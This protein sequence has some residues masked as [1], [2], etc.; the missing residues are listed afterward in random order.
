M[1]LDTLNDKLDKINERLRKIE[2]KQQFQ[3][4]ENQFGFG[5]LLLVNLLLLAGIGAIAKI[6]APDFANRLQYI[7]LLFAAG[8]ILLVCYNQWKKYYKQTK[9]EIDKLKAEGKKLSSFDEFL[10]H[11]DYIKAILTVMIIMIGL[12]IGFFW[13]LAFLISSYFY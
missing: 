5:L 9:E 3:I 10:K 11:F 13:G 6:I 7:F 12:P 8:P 1:S 2:E 4:K